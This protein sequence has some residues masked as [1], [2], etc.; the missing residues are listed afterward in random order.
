MYPIQTKKVVKS[1]LRKFIDRSRLSPHCKL[2]SRC[3]GA[4]EAVKVIIASECARLCG[5]NPNCRCALGHWDSD[6]GRTIWLGASLGLDAW[7]LPALSSTAGMH[8]DD[9]RWRIWP[10]PAQRTAHGWQKAL[11]AAW[12]VQLRCVLSGP[13]D[14]PGTTTTHSVLCVRRDISLALS[15]R[16]IYS[17][18][19]S[20]CA[21]MMLNFY[22][23]EYARDRCR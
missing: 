14:W 23:L 16:T 3:Y 15:P 10:W 6:D 18:S 22:L 11:A 5:L 20:V 17:S 7:L 21:F 8:D 13:W 4:V 19:S 1:K 9:E 2:V 12:H